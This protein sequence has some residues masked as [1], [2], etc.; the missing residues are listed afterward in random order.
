MINGL[1]SVQV[2]AG[3]GTGLPLTAAAS[4]ADRGRHRCREPHTSCQLHL[5]STLF[6]IKTDVKNSNVSRCPSCVSECH[7]RHAGP[8]AATMTTAVCPAATPTAS[9]G[10]AEGSCCHRSALLLQLLLSQCTAAHATTVNSEFIRRV[11]KETSHKRLKTILKKLKNYS[12]STRKL[13]YMFVHSAAVAGDGAGALGEAAPGPGA[14]LLLV[15][16]AVARPQVV[17]L[18]QSE[19]STGSRDNPSP[20]G[21]TRRRRTRPR[22]CWARGSPRPRSRTRRRRW[23]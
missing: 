9:V 13:R 18:H 3:H 11:S 16:D 7:Y 10:G 8:R 6:H 4:T 14:R 21:T 15:G 20:P 12:I 5:L 22:G 19:L 23:V 1:T 17:V 2:P